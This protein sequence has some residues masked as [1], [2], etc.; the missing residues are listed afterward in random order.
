MYCTAMGKALTAYLPADE[1]E[2]VLSSIHFERFTPRTLTRLTQLRKELDRVRERG[3]ALDDEETTLGARCVSAPIFG[4]GGKVTAAVSVAGP[5]T[6]IAR[7]KV[8]AYV[9]EVMAAA[10]AI[11]ARLG[12]TEM[13]GLE[14]RPAAAIA[15]TPKARA[16]G[17]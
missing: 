6:R 3:Y 13:P 4:D 14:I 2:H 8:P 11:A 7:D 1:K 16:Q 17:A 5:T 9:N 15:A 10:R 12:T